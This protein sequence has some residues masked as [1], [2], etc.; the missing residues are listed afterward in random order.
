MYMDKLTIG[1]KII[2]VRKK[3]GLTQ[4]EFGLQLGVT[5]QALSSWETGRT[6]P[7]IITLTEIAAKFGLTLNDFILNPIIQP[8]DGITTKEHLII[9]KLRACSPDTRYAIELLLGVKNNANN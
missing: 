6:L 8:E 4:S 3:L 7:D 9:Q 1:K 2:A 5:K